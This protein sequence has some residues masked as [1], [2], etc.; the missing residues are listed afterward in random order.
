M[1]ITSDLH[2][3]DNPRDEYRWGIFKFLRSRIFGSTYVAILGDLT[4]KKDGHSSLL[5]NRIVSELVELRRVGARIYIL[6]GNHDYVEDSIPFFNFL[7]DL[8][9]IHFITEPLAKQILGDKKSVFLPNT[10]DKPEELW[11]KDA[12]LYRYMRT[13]D[14]VFMHQSVMGCKLENGTVMQSGIR[15]SFFKSFKGRV[16][17]GDIHTPQTIGKVTYVGSPYHVHFGDKFDPRVI[18]IGVDGRIRNL[19]FQTI[20]KFTLVVSN[21]ESLKAKVIAHKVAKSDQ[22]KLIVELDE[23]EAVEW[24]EVCKGMESF[25]R[26]KEVDVEE[27]T[28]REYQEPE[29]FE[30]SRNPTVYHQID[31]HPLHMKD[32]K[33]I[34]V[35]Y[36]KATG[37]GKAKMRAAF[38]IAG[39]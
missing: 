15:P 2:L 31:C 7:N 9:G 24:R 23:D 39:L 26:K 32:D 5:V 29:S 27:I 36:G 10:K 4:D 12:D 28:V 8:T 35:T 14:Y 34:L 17:S 30:E 25:L 6:K 13:A 16:F 33:R 19:R 3:T 37:V 21:L 11:K 22:V 18:E 38:E 1:L 20:R